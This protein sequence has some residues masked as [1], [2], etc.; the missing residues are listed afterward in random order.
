M[1]IPVV[2]C[3]FY[4]WKFEFEKF[5]VEVDNSGHGGDG[6]SGGGG[7]VDVGVVGVAPGAWGADHHEAFLF[8]V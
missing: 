8:F 3:V 5:V 7:G 2:Y 1:A 4:S 6:S